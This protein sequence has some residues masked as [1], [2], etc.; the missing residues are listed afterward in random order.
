MKRSLAALA[1][2]ALTLGL[3]TPVFA[4][5]NY[6]RNAQPRVRPGAQEQVARTSYKSRGNRNY[7]RALYNSLVQGM[8][9]SLRLTVTGG[10]VNTDLV[11]VA[12]PGTREIDNWA[13]ETTG[14]HCTRKSKRCGD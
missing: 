2:V 10:E 1:S 8:A 7:V 14:N 3:A 12:R 9:S 6:I 11:K 13:F 4:S 5:S